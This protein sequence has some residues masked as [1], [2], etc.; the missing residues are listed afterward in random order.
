MVRNA[1][2]GSAVA[3]VLAAAN[4][5]QATQVLK[6]PA[7]FAAFVP[8]LGDFGEVVIVEGMLH[9][10]SHVSVNQ[11]GGV[12]YHF[13]FNPSGLKGE[14]ASGL[15]YNGTGNTQDKGTILPGETYSFVNNYRM[16]GQGRAPNLQVH[17]NVHVTFNAN[18]EITA[19]VDNYRMTCK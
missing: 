8:C 7:G 14:S 10:T 9:V 13:L 6:A 15:A 12:N 1:L 18:G 5:A 4:S 17:Q 11:A 2:R 16:I 3:T 19:E